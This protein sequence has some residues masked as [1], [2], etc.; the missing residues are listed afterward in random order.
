MRILLLTL[1]MLALTASAGPAYAIR[2]LLVP[3][4]RKQMV[5]YDLNVEYGFHPEPAIAARA[6]MFTGFVAGIKD[7]V[8]LSNHACVPEEVETTDA[9][10][11]VMDGFDYEVARALANYDLP[12]SRLC[13]AALV[14]A[15][16]LKK[17]PCAPEPETE[18][19]AK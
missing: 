16:L 3:D 15:I 14:F 9:I 12:S 19:P 17:W 10:Q 5:T 2:C 18:P 1:L 7:E 6:F 13:S 11:A 4:M 8:T